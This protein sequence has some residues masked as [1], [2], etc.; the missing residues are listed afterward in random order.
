MTSGFKRD[1]FLAANPD[2][3]NC[4][5]AF[6]AMECHICC[7]QFCRACEMVHDDTECV[8]AS[9]EEYERECR[10][11]GVTPKPDTWLERQL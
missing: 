5:E 8:R 11:R 3:E 9:R 7:K 4:N 2:C 1:E 6:A 10:D